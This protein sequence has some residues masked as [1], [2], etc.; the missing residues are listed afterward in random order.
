[1]CLLRYIQTSTDMA[2]NWG[3]PLMQSLGYLFNLGVTPVPPGRTSNQD[4]FERRKEYIE[5]TTALDDDSNDTLF[6]VAELVLIRS[7][8][9]SVGLSVCREAQ[10]GLAVTTLN[11]NIFFDRR[12]ASSPIWPQGR[13]ME[14]LKQML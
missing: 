3:D 1:M 2:I 7:F 4:E 13:T 11:A 8:S 10:G 12:N 6:V 9:W 5:E 14:S